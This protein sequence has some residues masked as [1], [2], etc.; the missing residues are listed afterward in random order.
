MLGFGVEGEHGV[1]RVGVFCGDLIEHLAGMKQGVGA[2]EVR[3]GELRAEEWGEVEAMDDDLRVELQE[4][5][6]RVI[7]EWE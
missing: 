6:E 5:M 7:A 1:P 3:G 2:E 4:E